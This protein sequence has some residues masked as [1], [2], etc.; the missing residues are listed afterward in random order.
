[1]A[2]LREKRQSRV[3]VP[4]Q[5]NTILAKL[6]RHHL[7]TKAKVGRTSDSHMFDLETRLCAAIEYLGSD[8]DSRAIIPDDVRSWSEALAKG[9]KRRPSTVHHD[10]SVLSGLYGR[11]Q[12]GLYVTP[13][14]NPVAM[15]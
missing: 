13:G 9:G 10:M 8:R 12:E 15:L 11:A 6:V 4:Q 1:M 7:I 3:G 2:E 14:Y 5:N